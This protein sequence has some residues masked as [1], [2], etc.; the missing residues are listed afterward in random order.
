M[1]KIGFIA[2]KS[3]TGGKFISVSTEYFT[4]MRIQSV[5]PGT[6]ASLLHPPH[7]KAKKSLF[8]SKKIHFSKPTFGIFCFTPQIVARTTPHLHGR[9]Q[10]STARPWLGL[11]CP[12]K[13]RGAEMNIPG[14]FT[15]L[16]RARPGRRSHSELLKENKGFLS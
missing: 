4:G 13:P 15:A 8:Y 14:G 10:K 12:P 2:P 3:L 9:A 5:Q 7:W 1:P 16:T 6:G 11:L